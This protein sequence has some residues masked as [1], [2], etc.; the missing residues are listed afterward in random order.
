M[1]HTLLT[2]RYLTSRVI[3]F[4]AVA[5]VALCVALV[6]IVVSVMTGFL[7]MVRSSGRTLMGDVIVSYSLT[8][9]P[10]YQR[11]ITHIK[12][13]PG[14]PTA[15]PV[16]DSWGL[17]K[18][19]YPA[20][21]HKETETVQVWG[22][23]P[24]GF[25]QVTGYAD[26][27]YW[28]PYDPR[29]LADMAGNDPRRILNEPPI[30]ET[31]TAAQRLEN[32]ALTLH[33]PRSNRPGIV[34]GVHVSEGNERQSDG[35]IQPVGIW[36]MPQFEVTLTMLPIDTGGGIIPQPANKIF[37]VVNEFFSGVFLIDDTRVMIPLS[38]AQEMLELSEGRLVDS[39]TLDDQGLP[40][41]IGV[42]PARATM[43]L[44]RAAAGVSPDELRSQV[45]GAYESFQQE[46]EADDT[47]LVKPPPSGPAGRVS[48][49][50][51]EEQQAAFIDPIEKER[52]LM[53]TL[54]SLVYLVCAGL[55]LSIFWAIVHE[56]TRDIG[57][58]RSM[59][60]SRLGISWIFLRYGLVIGAAGA[61]AGLGLAYLVVHNINAIHDA[62]GNPP[63]WLA[64]GM[65]VLALLSLG[66]TVYKGRGGE[67]MPVTL[68][69]LVT[70]SLFGVGA[71]ILL[72]KKGGGIVVWDPSVYYFT[73]I[74]N[75][76]D[77]FSAVTTMAGAVVFSLIGAFLPAA[78]AADTD[79]VRALRYE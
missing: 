13:L 75:T 72:L 10:Y 21:D 29:E 60:A 76:M 8:G 37:P 24:E 62:M 61:V 74:P 33:D 59:G 56:K 34:L 57:I 41:D 25:A 12:K 52:E 7:D 23:E 36:W 22:I 26:A 18:M 50:T 53:R 46:L 55:V 67:L 77:T 63:V 47:A 11:L 69:A 43:V 58:L 78:K 49:R 51:W 31:R 27:L 73:E 15:T 5:A 3:P 19:P 28:R 9:I 20:G 79:P 45:Q 54:F 17:L 2:N 39:K 14:E 35:S 32:D 1:Y 6:I 40:T 68:G 48:I 38:I 70:I 42:D 66:L 16:V 4:I 71:V 65:L 64:I 44:V 30:G